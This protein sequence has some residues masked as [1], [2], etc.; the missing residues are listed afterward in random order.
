MKY[1]IFLFILIG[2]SLAQAEVCD[3]MTSE[4]L[5]VSEVQVAKPSLMTLGK[6]KMNG[7]KIKAKR[8][9]LV[10]KYVY[11]G[12][13]F[14]LEDD[15]TH[16]IELEES[17]TEAQEYKGPQR[18]LRVFTDREK[19]NS[20][21]YTLDFGKQKQAWVTLN[22]DCSVKEGVYV[23]GGSRCYFKAS[24]C[25]RVMPLSKE[26]LLEKCSYLSDT[27]REVLTAANKTCEVIMA[28]NT[29][30]QVSKEKS[31]VPVESAPKKGHR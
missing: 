15:L 19:S 30:P 10:K 22:P 27:S 16:F 14:D 17:F 23:D 12:P 11:S 31:A 29:K 25:E 21:G 28:K 20:I 6:E 18:K 24:E 26:K 5:K 3:G 2:V 9:A 4:I 8:E 7:K 13:L 1:T